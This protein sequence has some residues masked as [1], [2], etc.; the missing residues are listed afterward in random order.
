MGLEDFL[1]KKNL[2]VYF[3]PRDF[4]GGCTAEA[5]GF[6][7]AYEEFKM[8]GAEVIGIS[9]DNLESH[10]AFAREHKLPFILLSDVD[11]AARRAYGVKKSLGLIPGRVS[12]VIDKRGVIRHI[13]SSQARAT[14]H[15]A[16]ALAV[17]RSL[18]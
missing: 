4:S 10:E 11:G 8:A 12:F 7:D 14:A 1:G 15:V 2:V 18:T 3:Y 6:R 5:C 16:E 9:G 13:F 17:L